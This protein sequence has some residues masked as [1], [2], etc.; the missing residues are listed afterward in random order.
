MPFQGVVA[1]DSFQTAALLAPSFLTAHVVRATG[2]MSFLRSFLESWKKVEDI[3]TSL[4]ITSITS[5]LLGA[6]V[7]CVCASVDV[8]EHSQSVVRIAE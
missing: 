1:S 7:V 3:D 4:D 5:Q 2:P 6:L 8:F